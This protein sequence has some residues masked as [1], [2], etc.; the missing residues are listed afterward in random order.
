MKL[1]DS[2]DN[3]VPW[4]IIL[5]SHNTVFKCYLFKLF[6]ELKCW[7]INLIQNVFTVA[8]MW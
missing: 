5:N 1:N 2:I 8:F 4:F 7:P 6:W 3:Y